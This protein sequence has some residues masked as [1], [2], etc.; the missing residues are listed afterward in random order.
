VIQLLNTDARRVSEAAARALGEMG[1]TSV[2]PHLIQG[3]DFVRDEA[4]EALGKL[5]D[6]RA[7]EP[8][9]A[10]LG[11]YFSGSVP[12]PLA[13]ALARL[14]DP[15]AIPVLADLLQHRDI[16]MRKSAAYA[17]GELGPEAAPH[18]L[19]VVENTEQSGGEREAA[20]KALKRIGTPEALAAYRRWLREHG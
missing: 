1:D 15:R 3:L 6:I 10:A 18:L 2:L 11:K 17:L 16:A 14:K 7:V 9:L 19:R 20:A 5:G 8:L 4:A 12:N 13:V